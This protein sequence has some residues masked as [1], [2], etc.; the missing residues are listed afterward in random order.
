MLLVSEASEYTHDR[1]V[2]EQTEESNQSENHKKVMEV[3]HLSCIAVEKIA[4]Y[5]CDPL[6]LALR[7]EAMEAACTIFAHLA[8]RYKN[9]RPEDLDAQAVSRHRRLPLGAW[10]T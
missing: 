1:N 2:A 4:E 3:L 9:R 7:D 8:Y 5:L 10:Q 6:R